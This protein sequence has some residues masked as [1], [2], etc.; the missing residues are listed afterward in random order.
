MKV[1][2]T[3]SNPEKLESYCAALRA[4]GLDPV[5][6]IAGK[7]YSLDGLSGL[8]IS[9]GPDLDP[10][11][12]GEE[13]D[14]SEEPV[15]DRDQM[16][17]SLLGDALNRDLPVLCIC[18]GLQLFNVWHQGSLHQHLEST[19]T[20]RQKKAFDAHTVAVEPGTQLAAAMGAAEYPVNSRHHQGVKELGQGI[21]VSARA[22][23][24]MIEGLERPDRRFAV[25]VQWHPEDRIASSEHDRRLFEAFARASGK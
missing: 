10:A 14:G 11:L 2:V 9:G 24:G 6:L 5:P 18:R 20:H 7:P 19:E 3:Y 1:G 12:Y 4:V 22:H 15:P 8:L 13:P 23:D 16:E 25:A 17:M 21:V